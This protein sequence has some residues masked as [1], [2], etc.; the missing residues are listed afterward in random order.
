MILG[1]QTSAMLL[2]VSQLAY[3]RTPLQ[4]SWITQ[5]SYD[6]GLALFMGCQG[7]VAQLQIVPPFRS[8]FP[9]K[10]DRTWT[11]SM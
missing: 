3:V 2:V 5:S 6:F 11:V 4:L 9:S 10:H 7:L 8:S 1:G